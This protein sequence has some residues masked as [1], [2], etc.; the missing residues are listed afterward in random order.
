MAS[1][2]QPSVRIADYE[3][4]QG[5]DISN[6][7]GPVCA[8]CGKPYQRGKYPA[9]ECQCPRHP[10]VI[11]GESRPGH[12]GQRQAEAME[13]I[14]VTLNKIL[15]HLER[16]PAVAAAL[17]DPELELMPAM[18]NI[19]RVTQEG[20]ALNPEKLKA[21]EAAKAATI[22]RMKGSGRVS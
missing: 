21:N 16:Q 15:K 8:D 13:L 5:R 2:T 12:P 17:A 1:A 9:L 10:A 22:E 4:Q 6:N 11:P 18:L 19:P 3:D 7:K 14:A 20:I